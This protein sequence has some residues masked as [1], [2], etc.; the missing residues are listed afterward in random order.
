M[1]CPGYT[2]YPSAPHFFLE[3]QNTVKPFYNMSI[4]GCYNRA[5]TYTPLLKFSSNFFF[6]DDTNIS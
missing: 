2:S 3:P 1:K 4:Y 6:K 5:P